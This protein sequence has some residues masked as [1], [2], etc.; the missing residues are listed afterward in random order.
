MVFGPII[1]L[2]F[3]QLIKRQDVDDAVK[4]MVDGGL[5]WIQRHFADE[6]ERRPNTLLSALG[7]GKMFEEA[8]SQLALKEIAM[9]AHNTFDLSSEY[10]GNFSF[11]CPSELCQIN[12]A[13]EMFNTYFDSAHLN[14]QV[15]DD[16]KRKS[17]LFVLGFA[18]VGSLLR[19]KKINHLEHLYSHSKLPELLVISGSKHSKKPQKFGEFDEYFLIGRNQNSKIS[20]NDHQNNMAIHIETTLKMQQA[21][22]AGRSWRKLVDI[23][24]REFA[25]RTDSADDIDGKIPKLYEMHHNNISNIQGETSGKPQKLFQYLQD[26]IMA[27]GLISARVP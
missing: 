1:E 6:A 22:A 20:P 7:T 25:K 8:I 11:L 3:K 15:E 27:D 14:Q 26:Q 13:I 4:K 23:A 24:R 9:T 10:F 16:G 5:D 19:Q 12:C 21:A 2:I 17:V 18:L